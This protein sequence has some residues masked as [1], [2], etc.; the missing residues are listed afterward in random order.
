MRD[1]AA[2]CIFSDVLLLTVLFSPGSSNLA[3]PPRAHQ[4]ALMRYNT[5]N[6]NKDKV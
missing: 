4:R 1:C 2:V 6:P 3:F 5:I